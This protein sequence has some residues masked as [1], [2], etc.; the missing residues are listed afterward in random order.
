M[1]N[2]LIYTLQSVISL[3]FGAIIYILFRKNTYL[4]GFLNI[5]TPLLSNIEF[6]AD[7]L[8][9]YALPDF[10][11]C[12]SFT[13][14]IYAVLMPQKKKGIYAGVFCA[15]SGIFWEIL[16][17]L[18]VVSGTFDLIDCAMYIFASYYSYKIYNKRENF[19]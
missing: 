15:F 12:Y 10:L 2:R 19:K 17:K 18:S 7:N 14:M 1:K 6:F 16:Q 4:H 8:I 3:T 9:R 11:W 13:M 5:S